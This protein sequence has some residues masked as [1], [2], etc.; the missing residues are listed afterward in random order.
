[1]EEGIDFVWR[2]N[3]RPFFRDAE[4][5]KIYMDV[6]DKVPY[7]NHGRRTLPHQPACQAAADPTT[8]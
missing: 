2:A 4:V 3:C 7:L 6:E 5:N 1:M 8:S